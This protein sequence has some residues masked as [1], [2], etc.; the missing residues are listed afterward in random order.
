[1]TIPQDD[2]P[3]EASSTIQTVPNSALYDHFENIGMAKQKSSSNVNHEHEKEKSDDDNETKNLEKSES[4]ATTQC[5]LSTI[6]ENDVPA[7][8]APTLNDIIN[9]LKPMYNF[10]MRQHE[11]A[12]RTVLRSESCTYCLKK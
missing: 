3:I 1:M 8:S 5:T 4:S 7:P 6:K 12:N 9:D 11:F 2:G 10:Q